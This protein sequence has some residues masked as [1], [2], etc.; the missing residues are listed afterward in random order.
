MNVISRE[1]IDK[2]IRRHPDGKSSIEAWYYEAKDSF[3]KNSVDIK[4]K[5]SSASFLAQ[6]YVIFNIKGN[7]YRLVTKIAYNSGIV[8]IKWLGTHAEYDKKTFP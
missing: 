1:V 6:N 4:E 5:Y 8:L 2:F 3:W 7:S